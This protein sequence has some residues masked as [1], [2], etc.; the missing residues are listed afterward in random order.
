MFVVVD[1][2]AYNMPCQPYEGIVVGK[3]GPFRIESMLSAG[4]L[5]E[6]RAKSHRTEISL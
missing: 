4:K 6:K 1:G 3:L 5:F 2:C